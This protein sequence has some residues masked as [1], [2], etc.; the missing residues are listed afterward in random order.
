MQHT[1]IRPYR[2]LLFDID[3][4]LLDF[5]A[6]ERAALFQTMQEMNLPIQEP[7]YRMYLSINQSVWSKFEA[8]LLDSKAVQRLRFE[9]FAAYLHRDPA[10]G[11]ALN[12]RYVEN[13]SRQAILLD[14]ALD[15]LRQLSRRYRLAVVTNG[16]T[17]VQRERLERSGFLPFLAGVFISQEMGVQ[18]P[19]REYFD[20]VLN[21]LGDLDRTQYLVI[22]DSPSAD[23]QGGVNAEIDTCW[24]LKDGSAQSASELPTYTVHGYPELLRLLMP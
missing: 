22:G 12:E 19:S 4:T 9:E 17:L 16:L 10:E 14:G 8:G 23:I 21:A 18:K 3:N 5:S 7:D 2:Y 15:A 6:G 20:Y 1:T 11:P 24:F 13:L